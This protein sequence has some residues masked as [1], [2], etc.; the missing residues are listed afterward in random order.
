MITSKQR[1]HLR[2]LANSIDT[3]LMIGKD[4]MSSDIEKQADDALTARELIKGKVLESAG[5][6]A[7]QAADELAGPLSAEVVQVIGSKFVLYRKNHKEPK[8]V[9]PR[10]P[11]K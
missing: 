4:G 3:I 11:R 5:M 2:S 8:I 9:L 7:R 6:T 10:A 1:A